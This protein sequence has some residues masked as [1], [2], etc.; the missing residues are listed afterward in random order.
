MGTPSKEELNQALKYAINM[1][2]HDEDPNFIA[3][4]LLNHHYRLKKTENIINIVKLY[5]RTGCATTEHAKMI[6]ALEA[7]DSIN[8]E[9][10]DYSDF[11]LD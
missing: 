9:V 2:E 8:H 3:K 1:R 5:L 4:S 10:A 11:G 6:K 7:Y